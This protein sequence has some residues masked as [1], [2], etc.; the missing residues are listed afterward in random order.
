MF[1][2]HVMR[3]SGTTCRLSGSPSLFSVSRSEH[4]AVRQVRQRT[5]NEII[6]NDSTQMRRYWINAFM[7]WLRTLPSLFQGWVTFQERLPIHVS[8]QN[9]TGQNRRQCKSTARDGAVWSRSDMAVGSLLHGI[10]HTYVCVYVCVFAPLTSLRMIC[11]T[12]LQQPVL[13][14]P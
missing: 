8:N 14:N 9:M 3:I 12:D 13:P 7:V 4:R 2:K 1:Y 11:D 5:F 10:H 6:P